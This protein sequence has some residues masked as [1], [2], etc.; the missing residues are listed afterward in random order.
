M[1]WLIT[2]VNNWTEN[3]FC[4]T[5]QLAKKWNTHSSIGVWYKAWWQKN[6][7]MCVTMY[8]TL[9]A[10]HVLCIM[11]SKCA[12]HNLPLPRNMLLNLSHL[13]L[14]GRNS[15]PIYHWKLTLAMISTWIRDHQWIPGANAR[16][17]N[18]KPLL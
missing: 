15:K 2:T 4:W 8:L 13:L 18:G 1:F 9:H 10:S 16:L 3:V 17:G 11:I 5:K 14:A 6:D 7:E 12:F